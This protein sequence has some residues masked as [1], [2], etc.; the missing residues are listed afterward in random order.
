MTSTEPSC[1]TACLS[2]VVSATG[3]P[4]RCQRTVGRGSPDTK[5]SNDTVLPLGVSVSRGG[6]YT[7]GATA[8]RDAHDDV[9]RH[10]GDAAYVEK[11][12]TGQKR[13][14]EP[15]SQLRFDYDTTTTKN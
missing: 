5:Q 9:Y 13:N 11:S 1:V 10:T 2:L 7:A 6:R 4:P 3:S 12:L 14:L 15:I 8:Q